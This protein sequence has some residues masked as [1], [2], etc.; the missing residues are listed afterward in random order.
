MQ[1][2]A[3]DGRIYLPKRLREK[4]GNHFE[5]VD[6]GDRIVLIP[7]ADDPLTALREE[8]ADVDASVEELKE[9][10]LEEALDEAG[11]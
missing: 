7:V 8:F 4:F 3:D 2:D 6:R 10:A 11:S 5:L 9:R 1:V